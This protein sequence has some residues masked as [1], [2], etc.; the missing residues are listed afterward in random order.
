MQAEY[1]R[2][3]IIGQICGGSETLFEDGIAR[4]DII[5]IDGQWFAMIHRSLHRAQSHGRKHIFM[6]AYMLLLHTYTYV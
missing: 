6:Y 4:G 5:D 1:T 3:Q 2:T